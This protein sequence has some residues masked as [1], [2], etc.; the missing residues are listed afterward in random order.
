MILT[1]ESGKVDITMPE[2]LNA[3]GKIQFREY[4]GRKVSKH[5]GY[6]MRGNW[7]QSL[8]LVGRTSLGM[9]TEEKAISNLGCTLIHLK[10]FI[11]ILMFRLNS[12][13]I[14]Q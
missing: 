8:E 7:F 6:N 4:H 10:R 13:A 3:V 11:K 14:K 1:L 5:V 12:K 9:L 2:S